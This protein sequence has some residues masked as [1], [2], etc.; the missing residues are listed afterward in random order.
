MR[1]DQSRSTPTSQLLPLLFAILILGAPLAG[2][3]ILPL[4]PARPA[5]QGAGGSLT[6]PV[7]A[8]GDGGYVVG[9]QSDQGDSAA[10]LHLRRFDERGRPAAPAAD[11]D[12]TTVE[13]GACANL[14]VTAQP[15]GTALAFWS[16]SALSGPFATIEYQILATVVGANG[17]PGTSLPASGPGGALPRGVAAANFSDGLTLGSW[18]DPAGNGDLVARPFDLVADPLADA[19]GLAPWKRPQVAALD[20][21]LFLVAAETD[22]FPGPPGSLAG[23]LLGPGGTP[24]GDAFTIHDEAARVAALAAGGFVAAWS[25]HDKLVF[26]TFYSDGTPRGDEVVIPTDD[27]PTPFLPAGYD[28]DQVS[29]VSVPQARGGEGILVFAW[30]QTHDDGGSPLRQ[31][32]ARTV[33]TGGTLLGPKVALS[34]VADDLSGVGLAST[35]PGSFLATWS[36][37]CGAAPCGATPDPAI[38]TRPFAVTTDTA[39]LGQADRFEISVSWR[40]FQGNT[41][42]GVP[43]PFTDDTVA[44]WFFRPGNLELM[45]KVLD[46]RPVNGHFW[47]FGGALSSVAYTITVTD[48][49]TGATRVYEN[50]ANELTSFADTTAFPE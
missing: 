14:A 42:V 40:D 38:W 50:P 12:T 31:A 22:L 9:W 28:V 36:A 26:R 47:V 17:T 5:V 13:G 11:L 8:A 10:G 35:A 19:I 49:L 3:E 39:T 24:L 7:I 46:G 2:A 33:T 30:R 16:R 1:T 48:T 34:P 6:C 45:V 29:V 41:G 20:G 43:V 37:G 21:D 18:R 4:D 15:G 25:A 44:F 32:F 23:R 27:T